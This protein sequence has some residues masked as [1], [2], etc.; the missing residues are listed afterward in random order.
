MITF[1]LNY[2]Y[3]IKIIREK[4]ILND[5]KVLPDELI[6]MKT[7]LLKTPKKIK[8]KNVLKKTYYQIFT[9]FSILLHSYCA[10]QFP[11]ICS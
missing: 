10:L 8:M 9:N 6:P 7:N 3:R 5:F 2:S 11:N 4:W 1:F